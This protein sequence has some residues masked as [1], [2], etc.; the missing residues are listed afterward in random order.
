M[1]SSPATGA[2]PA[3]LVREARAHVAAHRPAEARAAYEAALALD[4][5][6]LPAH[7]GLAELYMGTL[8]PARA[9]PHLERACELRPAEASIWMGRAEAVALSG[10]PE[11]PLLDAI[12]RAPVDAALRRTISARFAPDRPHP[13]PTLSATAAKDAVRINGLMARGNWMGAARAAED[14]E[15]SHPRVAL[16]AQL[17]GTAL[18]RAGQSRAAMQA[19]AKAV[20]LD[21]GWAEALVQLGRIALKAGQPK[22]ALQPLAQAVSHRPNLVPALVALAQALRDHGL[23]AS[24]LPLALKAARLAPKDCAAQEI[25]VSTLMRTPAPDLDLAE[26]LARAAVAANPRSLSGLGYLGHVLRR[27]GRADEAL[28]TYDRLLALKPDHASALSEKALI[29]Q[30]KGEFATAEKM[31]LDALTLDPTQGEV[32]LTLAI[33]HKFTADDPLLAQMQAAHDRPDLPEGARAEMGFALA[34]AME[35]IGA[36]DRVFTYLRPANDAINRLHPYSPEAR[37]AKLD[38]LIASFRGADFTPLDGASDF[39]PIFV[40]GMP[41]SGTTLIEQIIASHSTVT[42]AGEAAAFVRQGEGLMDDG[43]GGI[44]GFRD[45][46]EGE[47]LRLGHAYR[48]E[49][50]ARFPGAERVSDKSIMTYMYLGAIRRTLP[51]ARVVVVRRDPR[52]NLLSIYKN[53]FAEG[54][55]LYAY[56]LENLAHYYRGFLR[57]V[58]FWKEEL[59]DFVHEVHYEDLVADPEPQARALIA[60]CNLE[61][62]DACLKFHEN[63]REVRTLSVYQARQPINTRSKGGWRRYETELAPLIA[64][65]DDLLP[66]D[67]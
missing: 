64:A 46:P 44:R 18:A 9:L 66:E 5:A 22:A 38:A 13:A 32:W 6:Y 26:R 11:A 14:A 12:A 17:R 42:G 35:D 20:A 45:I 52:D 41:R 43:H 55:H 37:D 1:S 28:S 39:A 29:L 49:M 54:T 59:G 40:T 60:A 61:W 58:A 3:D 48:D 56:N 24:A 57:M 62:E 53:R 36:H 19:L 33:G 27:L 31:F 21:P 34:K 50:L 51:N 8:A 65:L 25:A 67:R 47:I 2:S 30:T 4:A 15:R 10:A 16:F 63:T 23:A 7:L